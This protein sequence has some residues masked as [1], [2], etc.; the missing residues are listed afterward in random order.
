MQVRGDDGL[1]V[2][3]MLITARRDDFSY[4]VVYDML[5]HHPVHPQPGP[6]GRCWKARECGG[7]PLSFNVLNSR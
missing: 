7:L 1:T 5:E 6:S 4:T 2:G 3:G